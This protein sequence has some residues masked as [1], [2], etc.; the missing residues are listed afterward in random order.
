MGKITITRI[1]SKKDEFIKAFE[2][3][4][5]F[6]PPSKD[7]FIK[8]EYPKLTKEKKDINY[9]VKILSKFLFN[10]VSKD[11]KRMKIDKTEKGE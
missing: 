6:I 11:I 10:E 2:T 9:Y 1:K 3:F 8:I 7:T 5:G 4:W